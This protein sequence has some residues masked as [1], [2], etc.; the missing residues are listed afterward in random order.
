MVM[1]WVRVTVIVR[2]AL[3]VS[4]KNEK[5]GCGSDWYEK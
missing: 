5:V 4:V 2:V 3:R 1:V